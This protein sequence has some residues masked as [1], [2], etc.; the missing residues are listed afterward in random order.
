MRVEFQ[1]VKLPSV[2]SFCGAS[3]GLEGMLISRAH[4]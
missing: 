3:Q 1:K 2:I 4:F